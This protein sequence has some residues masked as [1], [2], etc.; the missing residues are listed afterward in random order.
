LRGFGD[1]TGALLVA[2]DNGLDDTDSD[3][4]SHVTDGETT[5]WW[6]VG[7]S[8][9]THWLGWH[10]LDDGSV[11][12]LDELR[13]VLNRLAGTAVDLLEEL[14]ELA[15][16]VGGVAV[17]DWSVTGTDL[18]WVVEDDNLGVEGVTALWWVVLGVTSNVSTTDLLDGD[19]LDVETD[20]ITRVSRLK[21]LVVHL[22]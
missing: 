1:F 13:A 7:E 4:L 3:G 6:V 11:T 12:R 22:N 14:R 5:E 8:L 20:V 9:D 21:L 16:N 18:T 15:G 19:V 17:E 2:L 10:H